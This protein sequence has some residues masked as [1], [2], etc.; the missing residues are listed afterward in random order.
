MR[1]AA[2]ALLVLCACGNTTSAYDAPVD[3]P[4]VDG[5]VI[6]DAVDCDGG[7]AGV[8]EVCGTSEGDLDAGALPCRSGLVCCY[9]CGIP[10]CENKCIK[11]DPNTNMCP[12]FP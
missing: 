4:T 5:P 12:L 11:P 7:C 8:G 1:L 6:T 3:A 9:P 10:D 2:I